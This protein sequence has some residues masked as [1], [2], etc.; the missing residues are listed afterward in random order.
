[1]K[2]QMFQ[3]AFLFLMLLFTSCFENVEVDIP[4]SYDQAAITGVS[5]Y[6]AAKEGDEEFAKNQAFVSIQSTV[7]LAATEE[8]NT[9]DIQ[10]QTT[11]DLTRLK[12][13]LTIS[14][15]ATVIRPLGATIQ[16]FSETKTVK[17]E[18]PSGKIVKEWTL[19]V[20]NP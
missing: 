3:L 5:V 12:I 19:Q 17:I 13:L 10:L 1:M 16:D 7:E 14:P 9:C 15:A 20:L 6:R 18:S 2:K 11:E 4:T 8:A